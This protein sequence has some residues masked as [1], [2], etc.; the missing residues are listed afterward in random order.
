LILAGFRPDTGGAA[1]ARPARPSRF[2]VIAVIAVPLSIHRGP[3]SRTC[4]SE[5]RSTA[6]SPD[7]MIAPASSTPKPTSP[8]DARPSSPRVG[9]RRSAIGVAARHRRSDRFGGRW[10]RLLYQ[11]DQFRGQCVMTEPS[12]GLACCAAVP[13]V[14]CSGSGRGEQQGSSRS[15]VPTA[16]S[17]PIGSSRR[18]GPRRYRHHRGTTGSAD[19]VD[20][21]QRRT[22]ER[23]STDVAIVPQVGSPRRSQAETSRLWART[24][25]RRSG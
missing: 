24:P 4:R 21:L 2:L 25:S 15:S 5:D 1:L 17:R 6:L 9:P 19:F 18:S 8:V 23:R 16:V 20:D 14:A 7:G 13:V 10:T 12:T 3:P 11:Q 22:G